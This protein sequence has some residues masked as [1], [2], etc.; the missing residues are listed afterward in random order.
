MKRK[1]ISGAYLTWIILL[2]GCGSTTPSQNKD[3][4]EALYHYK[5]SYGYFFES[6]NGD[7]AVQEI[8]QSLKRNEKSFQAH[9]L[10]GLIFSGRSNWLKAIQHYRRTIELNPSYYE[11][12]NNLSTVYLSLGQWEKAI[13]ILVPLVQIDEYKTPAISRN[14]L[15]WAYYKLKKYKKALNEFM[16]ANQYNPKLCPPYNN[17][18]LTYQALNDIDLSVRIF[19]KGLKECPNYVELYLNLGRVYLQNGHKQDALALLHKCHNMS[20]DS[21]I[22]LRCLT[23]MNK[24]K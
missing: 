9:F 12:H 19:N 1:I 5:L 22:G 21:S 24:M 17:V 23:L 15:G 8:L 2:Y 16:A 4:D 3:F 7:L 20:P 13:E 10:A 11:A 6:Q 14:N 18:G